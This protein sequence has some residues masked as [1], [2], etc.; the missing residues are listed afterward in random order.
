MLSS[1]EGILAQILLFEQERGGIFSHED[2]GAL[3]SV[4]LAY[5]RVKR[6]RQGMHCSGTNLTKRLNNH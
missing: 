5:Q 3:V 1:I 4:G 6:I 2:L